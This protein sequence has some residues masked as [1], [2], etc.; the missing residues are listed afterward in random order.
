MAPGGLLVIT[1]CNST[2][3]ELIEELNSYQESLIDGNS[4]SE[5]LECSASLA[6]NNAPQPLFPLF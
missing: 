4:N 6:S 2:K 5:V 1:S 3:D